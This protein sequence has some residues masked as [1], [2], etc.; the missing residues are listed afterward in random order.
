MSGFFFHSIIFYNTSSIIFF[1]VPAELC[2]F[3]VSSSSRAIGIRFS[4]PC[5]PTI[6]GMLK[7]GELD[8]VYHDTSLHNPPS[9]SHCYVGVL[10]ETVP[11]QLRHKVYCMHLD[12]ECRDMLESRG[13][14]VAEVG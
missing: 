6:A 4:T 1:K 14:R 12:G 8:A 9:P 10:E 11:Q 2:S 3:S 13:F 5:A 7:D